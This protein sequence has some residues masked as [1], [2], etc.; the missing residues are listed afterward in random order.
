L[1]AGKGE[2]GHK[3]NS[4]DIPPDYKKLMVDDG[5]TAH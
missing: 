4:I 3:Y 1:W 2:K 5:S